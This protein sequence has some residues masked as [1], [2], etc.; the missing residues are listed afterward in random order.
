ME[1]GSQIKIHRVDM[2]GEEKSPIAQLDMLL[3]D[4][5]EQVIKI[6]ENPNESAMR[7]SMLSE[8]LRGYRD[9]N[10]FMRRNPYKK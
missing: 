4:L 10:R 6:V 5:Q 7:I 2:S 8:Y 9:G 3:S 1:T